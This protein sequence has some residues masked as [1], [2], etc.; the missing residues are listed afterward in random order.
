MLGNDLSWS[1][2][3]W[4]H[5]HE[6]SNRSTNAIRG[7]SRARGRG[8]RLR[9][10]RPTPSGGSRQRPTPILLTRWRRGCCWM[11]ELLDWSWICRCVARSQQQRSQCLD[12]SLKEAK[13]VD[14]VD[15]LLVERA[16]RLGDA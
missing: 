5:H 6:S 13:Y 12:G 16:E 9:T 1:L 14:T 2:T 3:G 7:A 15:W 8:N 4:S 11:S 10:R